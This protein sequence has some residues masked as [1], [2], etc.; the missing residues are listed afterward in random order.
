MHEKNYAIIKLKCLAI[1]WAI[2]KCGFFLKGCPHFTVI[3]DHR[4]LLSI[5]SK[6]L[7]DISNPR[8][9]RLREKLMAYNFTTTWLQVK[10]NVIANAL[11]RNLVTQAGQ[12][13]RISSYIVGNGRLINNI[14][15]NAL[16]CDNYQQIVEALKWNKPPSVFAN[17]HPTKTVQDVWH[18]LSLSDANLI[19]M[20]GCRLFI[21]HKSRKGIMELLHK[22]HAGLSKT[23]ITARKYYY[24][25]HMRNDLIN[26]INKCENCQN[27]RPSLP[28]D[29]PIKSFANNPMEKLSSDLFETKGKHFLIAVDQFSGLQWLKPL[30]SLA[31]NNITTELN[32]I[33]REYGYPRS[34]RMDGGPQFQHEFTEFCNKYGIFHEKSSPYN[35]QSNGQAEVN[36]RILKNLILKTTPPT[37]K[38]AFSEWK[39]TEQVGRPSPN[40]LFFKRNL[41]LQLPILSSE[42]PYTKNEKSGESDHLRRLPIGS[43][44]W[45]QDQSG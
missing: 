32:K 23:L 14:K 9:V 24:W 16:A 25:P 10:Q 43:P 31:T 34:I 2:Q 37:F 7:A 13:N 12:E 21:P 40:T 22:P 45:M 39:N 42:Q 6:S 35:P 41:C 27:T 26:L 4:P 17:N 18:Q 33:F 1:V 36:V 30:R 19:I 5:F 20:D 28:S 38:E 8:L 11:S 3:M 44:V 29:V 15:N